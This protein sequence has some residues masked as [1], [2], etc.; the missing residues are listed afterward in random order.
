MVHL[1][2]PYS[3][4]HLGWFGQPFLYLTKMTSRWRQSR[5]LS[6]STDV[7]GQTVA[8]N[9][10]VQNPFLEK[11]FKKLEEWPLH[12]PTVN[13]AAIGLTFYLSKVRIPSDKFL[14][15]WQRR[16]LNK[17]GRFAKCYVYCSSTLLGLMSGIFCE[18][19]SLFCRLSKKPDV[20][21]FLWCWHTRRKNVKNCLS[22]P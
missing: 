15:M 1:P 16:L 10:S 21:K 9:F 11:A 3:Q 12:L 18:W 17:L 7:S 8:K 5:G 2:E 20:L 22:A 6:S 19:T 13:L 14:Y 4:D